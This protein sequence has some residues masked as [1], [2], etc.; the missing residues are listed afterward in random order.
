MLTTRSL[1]EV[2]NKSVNQFNDVDGR[3]VNITQ[4]EGILKDGNGVEAGFPIE[5]DEELG[6]YLGWIDKGRCIFV[7]TLESVVA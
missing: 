5:S 4:I 2:I 1:S 7:V 6:A 3:S